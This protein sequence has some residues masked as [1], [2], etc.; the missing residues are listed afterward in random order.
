LDVRR[1][2]KFGL[3][4]LNKPTGCYSLILSLNL[5]KQLN[6]TI[7][8]GAN[9]VEKRSDQSCKEAIRRYNPNAFDK[10]V[11]ISFFNDLVTKWNA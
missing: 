9:I 4:L 5:P 11:D 6:V 8:L 3:I 2:D 10:V 7:F 1:K